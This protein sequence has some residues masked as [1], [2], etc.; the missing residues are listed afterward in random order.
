[1]NLN[2]QINSLNSLKG[3]FIFMIVLFHIHAMFGDVFSTLF[4]FFISMAGK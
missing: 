2:K 1:M 3:I 4:G